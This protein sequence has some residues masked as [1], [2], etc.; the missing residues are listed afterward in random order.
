MS[1]AAACTAVCDPRFRLICR[2][3]CWD[4]NGLATK[5]EAGGRMERLQVDCLRATVLGARKHCTPFIN[6]HC[7]A[8]C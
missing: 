1:A 6:V 8:K 2:Q 5:L 7:I 3:A 4:R